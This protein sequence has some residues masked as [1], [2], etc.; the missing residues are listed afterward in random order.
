LIVVCTSPKPRIVT[1]WYVI[2]GQLAGVLGIDRIDD[3]LGVALAVARRLQAGAQ[4]DDDD[5][6]AAFAFIGCRIG[7]GRN[8]LLHRFA[9][10]ARGLAFC[11][12]FAPSGDPLGFAK[13]RG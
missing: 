13:R 9:A 8:G 7:T 12:R 11:A 2:V 10:A 3:L 4:A 1:F 6:V 5:V